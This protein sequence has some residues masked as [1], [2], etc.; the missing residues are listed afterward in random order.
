M[1]CTKSSDETRLRQNEREA[2][3]GLNEGVLGESRTDSLG[4]RHVMQVLSRSS[5]ILHSGSVESEFMV[6]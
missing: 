2:S 6:V 1:V 5:Q 3:I 4:G